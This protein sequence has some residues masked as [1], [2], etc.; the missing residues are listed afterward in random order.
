MAEQ[1]D[2]EDQDDT[3]FVAINPEF[4]VIIYKGAIL[5]SLAKLQEGMKQLSDMDIAGMALQLDSCQNVLTQVNQ[6]PTKV[7]DRQ[8]YIRHSKKNEPRIYKDNQQAL[9]KKA[10]ENVQ[11]GH[12]MVCCFPA[13]L[14]MCVTYPAAC[15]PPSCC[16]P[17]T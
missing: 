16:L 12:K 11:Q 4:V 13:Q 3:A 15:H 9:S 2:L 10:A 5:P 8:V 1:R 17:L 6:V 7:N 14:Y